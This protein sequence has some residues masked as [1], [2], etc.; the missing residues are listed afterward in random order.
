MLTES[1]YSPSDDFTE[2]TLRHALLLSNTGTKNTNFLFMKAFKNLGYFYLQKKEFEAAE[3][4]LNKSLLIA[5][6]LKNVNFV[7]QLNFLLGKLYAQMDNYSKA[8]EFYIISYKFYQFNN[9]FYQQALVLM[10]I[11]VIYSLNQDYNN[12]LKYFVRTYE[13]ITANDNIE[14]SVKSA[15][16]TELKSKIAFLMPKVADFKQFNESF[17]FK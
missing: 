17:F 2:G 14:D 5:N 13:V 1:S 12:A 10:E 3:E 4:N 11:G 15:H 6:K 9:F 8:L 16:I 7:A